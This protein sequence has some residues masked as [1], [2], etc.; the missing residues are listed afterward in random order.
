MIAKRACGVHNKDRTAKFCPNGG[1]ILK[2]LLQ[3]AAFFLI[4]ALLLLLPVCGVDASV[5]TLVGDAVRVEL[6]SDTVIRVEA[7][8]ASGFED[9]ATLIAA[10]RGDFPGVAAATRT[11][12]GNLIAETDRYIV[13]L[14]KG[15][16]LTADAVT[17]ADKN[18]N[19]LWR[20]SFSVDK[21]G[22]TPPAASSA[23]LVYYNYPGGNS[24]SDGSTPATAKQGWGATAKV[25]GAKGG[26]IVFSG[27]GYMGG[28][29]TFPKQSSPLYITAVAPDGTDYRCT[30]AAAALDDRTGTLSI[31]EGL[32][33]TLQSDTTFDKV[34]LLSSGAKPAT[35]RA[36]GG[37]VVAFGEG[38]ERFAA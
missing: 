24:L 2:Q 37:A 33:L 38:V 8:D 27:R 5:V 4:A 31:R 14:A 13:T 35:I 29:Y 22:L 36:T 7:K 3:I 26:T 25:L 16:A 15:K 19:I 18:G 17:V 1:I 30:D 10:G 23:N 9:R 6:L 28:S 20:Y 11:E 12:G 34:I 32:T 21:A